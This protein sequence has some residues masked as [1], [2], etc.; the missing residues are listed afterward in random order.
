M[1]EFCIIKNLM[2]KYFSFI[3]DWIPV[4]GTKV[5]LHEM[6]IGLRNLFPKNSINYWRIFVLICTLLNDFHHLYCL[7][8]TENASR[9]KLLLLHSLSK[10]NSVCLNYWWKLWILNYLFFLSSLS[11]P[12][13]FDSLPILFSFFFF[14]LPYPVALE[15]SEF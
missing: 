13:C 8:M 1:A 6:T 4:S 2:F 5:I 10:P 12:H 7:F 14:F 9:M 15:Q 11:S 3:G